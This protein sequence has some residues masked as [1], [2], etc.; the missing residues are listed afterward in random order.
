MQPSDIYLILVLTCNND[1]D[2]IKNDGVRRLTLGLALC[3]HTQR[4]LVCNQN[5]APRFMQL[6]R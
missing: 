6:S 5:R 1:N 4:W 2:W 3:A